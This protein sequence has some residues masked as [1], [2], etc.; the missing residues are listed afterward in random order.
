MLVQWLKRLAVSAVVE[1]LNRNGRIR[2]ALCE[3]AEVRILPLIKKSKEGSFLI[4][5]E[6]VVVGSPLRGK[7]GASDE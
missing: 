7:V 1:D 6:K 4:T 3:T 2:R 5:S